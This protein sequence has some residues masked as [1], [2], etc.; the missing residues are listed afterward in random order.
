MKK[1]LGLFLYIFI[2]LC[3]LGIKV[4]AVQELED[5]H[6]KLFEPVKIEDG[7]SLSVFECVAAAFQNSPKIRRQKYNLDIAKSNLGTAKSQYF[8]TISAGIG[9]YNENNS[10]SIY[11]DTHYRELPNVGLAVN[12]LI[13]NFGKS[14]AFIKM[15]EFNKIAAEYEFMDSLCETL[16]D[17]KD[18]YYNLLRTKALLESAGDDVKISEHFVKIS[19]KEPDKQTAEINLSQSKINFLEAEN[20]YNNAKVDLANSM[21]LDKDYNFTVK[22]TSTFNYN[23]D[24]DFLKKEPDIRIFTPVSF[25]F[26]RDEA[27]NIAYKNSPDLRILVAT[28]KAMEQA[29]K[30]VKRTYLPDLTGNV[31]YGYGNIKSNLDERVSNNSLQIGVNLSSEV[32]IKELYHGIKGADAQLKTADNE[33]DLFK[34]DLFFE[35]KRAFNNLD[36]SQRRIKIAQIEAEQAFYNLKTVI[37]IYKKGDVDYTALQDARKD[38]L[39]GEEAYINALFDYNIAL[40]QVEMAM[41]M[42]IADIHHKS[43]HAM[44]YHANELLEHINKALSCN[45]NETKKNRHKDLE[46]DL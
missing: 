32:N 41:H 16:F 12:Q 2:L 9:F 27:V 46:E 26:T 18:K 6:N 43:E 34:Q 24:F 39:S 11:H 20:N 28:K 42:H 45:E 44:R 36:K 21:Y 35:I 4:Y 5:E 38:F 14:T 19:S 13:Y 15:E 23:D 10:K 1:F 29:L 30:Y 31:S 17:I 33:I 3:I 22:D 40:I 7:S 8:P 37:D 25:S